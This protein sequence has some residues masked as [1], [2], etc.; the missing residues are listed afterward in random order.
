FIDAVQKTRAYLAAGDVFQVNLSRE[1][2][3]ELARQESAAKVYAALRQT[4]PAPFAGLL[5]WSDWAIASSSPERLVE[6]RGEQV[7]TRPIAGTRARI[8]NADMDASI[9]ELIGHPKE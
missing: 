1:W 8:E 6:V 9:R 5:Q 3:L 2:R 4:N 7:Q